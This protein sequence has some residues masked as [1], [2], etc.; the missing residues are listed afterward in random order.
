[1]DP[2]ATV[3]GQTIERSTLVRDHLPSA[4]I[5]GWIAPASLQQMSGNTLDPDRFD[6]CDTAGIQLAGLDQFGRNHPLASTA[7]QIRPRMDPETD[8]PH[9]AVNRCFIGLQANIAKQ[10]TEQST[11]NL[12]VSRLGLIHPPPLLCDQCGELSMHVVPFP[13]PGNRQKLLAQLGCKLA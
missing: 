5:P 8:I 2:A 3:N 10:T 1:M 12:F 13:Q 4:C 9:T 6:F 11:M 7:N